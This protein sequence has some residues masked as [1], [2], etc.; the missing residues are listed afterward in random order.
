MSLYKLRNEEN[1]YVFLRYAELLNDSFI[2]I[3]DK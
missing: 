3:W 2:I 1:N